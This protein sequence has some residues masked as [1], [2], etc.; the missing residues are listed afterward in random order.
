MADTGIG[1]APEYQGRIFAPF[2]QADFLDHPRVWRIGPGIDHHS[3]TVAL[4]G[5]R[6]WVESEPGQ[7]QH[8][9]FYGPLLC[10]EEAVD[11]TPG[12]PAAGRE[13]LCDKPVLIV[14]DDANQRPNPG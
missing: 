2:M 10:Q 4:M 5:G 14:A 3:P 9:S 13:A 6:I 7:G 8:F 11:E 1:I 12:L